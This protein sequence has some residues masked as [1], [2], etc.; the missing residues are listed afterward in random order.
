MPKMVPF[1]W[2]GGKTS[3]LGWLLPL[4]DGTPHT[5]YVEEFGG[6]AAVLLNKVPSPVELYN[7]LYSDVV[8]FFRVLRTQREELISLL[9]LTPFSREEFADAC[10][11]DELTDLECARRFFVVARQVRVGLATTASA[12]RWAYSIRDS[13]R[14]MSLTVSRWLSAIDGLEAVANRLREVQIENLDALDVMSRYDSPETLHYIDPPYLMDTR[15]GGTGYALEYSEAQH[16]ALLEA[17]KKLKGKVLLSGYRNPLY[18]STLSDWQVYQPAAHKT[19]TARNG[20]ASIR[21][22]VVW[23]NY[24]LPKLKAA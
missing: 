24:E 6:S 23:A 20:K 4:V 9:E 16:V 21:Q 15:P 3:H 8:T 14:G 10:T 11:R 2:F 18:Q 13:R 17:V 1:S 5:T 12:G 22:E 19:A 7:D